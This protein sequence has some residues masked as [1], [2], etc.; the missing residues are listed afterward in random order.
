MA[1]KP[2]GAVEE[3]RRG[4]A[5]TIATFF[6]LIVV[7]GLAAAW[8]YLGFYQL[9]PGQAAIVFELGK[10]DYIETREGL[11][12][13]WP[14]PVQTHEIVL[15]DSIVREEFPSPEADPEDLTESTMQTRDNNIVNLSFV[16]QYRIANAFDARYRL[17]SARQTLRDA[18]QAAVREVVGRTTIDD[19]LSDQRG[20]VEA[21]SAQILQATLDHYD[22]GILVRSVQL[23][24]V[25]PPEAVR[26][27][28]DDV[29][30]AAQDRDRKVN[31]AQ[32][33]ANE[34]L[35]RARAEATEL[36]QSAHAYRDEK[37]AAASGEG[38]RFTALVEEYRRAPAVTRERLYLEAM[39]DVLAGA[40]LVVIEQ[41]A[42]PVM[43]YLPLG[44]GA[45]Q[46]ATQ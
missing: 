37:I 13:H 1:D 39:Q 5:G 6:V 9:G 10:F 38:E 25:E 22:A 4:A 35:P 43:P 16:V 18:A 45:K 21:E 11:R 29:I 28:F 46:G 36:I 15:V 41:G 23:Q 34:V 2:E 3:A 31:E 14:P 40:E 32:G 19:V 30:A 17:A 33:Y 44:R 42:N 24:D 26:D 8:S 20:A 27:A 7:L 12:F